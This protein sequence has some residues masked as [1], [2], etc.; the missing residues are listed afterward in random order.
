MARHRPDVVRQEKSRT[1]S[2]PTPALPGSGSGTAPRPCQ[3]RPS[4]HGPQRGPT[5]RPRLSQTHAAVPGVRAQRVSAGK[6]SAPVFGCRVP[7]L[8][9]R[10]T[11]CQVKGRAAIP[12]RKPGRNPSSFHS[13]WKFFRFCNQIVTTFPSGTWY[14][15][16]ES[17]W[18][19]LRG[20]IRLPRIHSFRVS[21][22]PEYGK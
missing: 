2:L 3:P 20:F 15:D 8:I 5:G 7:E 22:G 1:A 16:F 19:E 10:Q 17:V 14:N 11:G 21:G 12:R 13:I 9:L 4:P 6:P 18:A